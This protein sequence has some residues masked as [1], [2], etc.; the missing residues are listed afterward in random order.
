MMRPSASA[1]ASASKAKVFVL[2]SWMARI[3]AGTPS[4][5][6]VSTMRSKSPLAS[7][8]TRPSDSASSRSTLTTVAAAPESVCAR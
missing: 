3:S 8:T 6:L 1:S 7:R 5:Y 2:T 4:G